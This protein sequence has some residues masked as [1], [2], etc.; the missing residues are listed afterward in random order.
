MLFQPHLDALYSKQLQLP[1]TLKLHVQHDMLIFDQRLKDL[2]THQHELKQELRAQIQESR[3]DMKA[4]LDRQVADYRD[5]LRDICATSK[6]AVNAQLDSQVAEYH[7]QVQDVATKIDIICGMTDS[8]EAV[9]DQLRKPVLKAL[10][11]KL[12]KTSVQSNP[13][14]G[15]CGGA[16]PEAATLSGA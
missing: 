10:A 7:V 9:Q 2:A 6:K 3:L 14:D 8:F 12:A 15:A 1:K 16:L 13:E 4:K 11:L 5:Q